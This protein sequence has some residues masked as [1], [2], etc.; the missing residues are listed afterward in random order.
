MLADAVLSGGKG[1][2][3][4]SGGFGRNARTTS[5]L[6]AALIEPEL[7]VSIGS[8][9]L[10]TEEPYL[11][12]FSATLRDG[13]DH[14]RV[15]DALFAAFEGLATDGV[16]DHG[17]TK[18]KNQVLASLAFESEQITQIAHQLGYYATIASL[19]DLDALPARVAS[20][21]A[22]E[23]RRVAAT[24]LGAETRTV[25]WVVPRGAA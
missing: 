24:V 20:T 14:L 12:S 13:V 3:L 25:G 5:P 15:E 6:Y 23:V 17:L 18:A 21:P 11:Y 10:P 16:D 7:V 2:N 1:A 8:A 4:W 19:E 22:D 9:L